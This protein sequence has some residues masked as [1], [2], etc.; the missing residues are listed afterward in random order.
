M[1]RHE[2]F[3]PSEMQNSFDVGKDTDAGGRVCWISRR[4][5]RLM[6]FNSILII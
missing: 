3:S 2:L 4:L 5:A 1:T 6:G